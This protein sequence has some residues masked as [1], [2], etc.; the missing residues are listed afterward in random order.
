MTSLPHAVLWDMD[1]TLIDSEAYWLNSEKKLAERY[2]SVWTHEDGMNM[3]GLSL[4]EST[5]I[6]RNRMGIQDMSSDEVI[7]WL[8]NSVMGE[9]QNKI[10]W[11]PGARELLFA[12]REAGVKTA[13]VTMSYRKMALE[14]VDAIGFSAFDVVVAGDD[15]RNGKPHPEPYLMAADLLGVLP[16]QCIAIEDSLNGLASAEA[17]GTMALGVKHL[18]EIPRSQNRQVIQTLVGL[19]PHHLLALFK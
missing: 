14:V 19:E 11:R 10:P 9:L 12:L 3:V 7:E 16:E 2:E 18:M 15:V 5:Q 17:A 1:G 8:T 6:M 13:L 4:Q